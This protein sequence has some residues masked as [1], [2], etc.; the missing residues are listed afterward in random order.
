LSVIAL[1]TPARDQCVALAIGSRKIASK[2]HGQS[3]LLSVRF[4]PKADVRA[5]ARVGTAPRDS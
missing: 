1:D 5:R 2:H 4:W 3:A